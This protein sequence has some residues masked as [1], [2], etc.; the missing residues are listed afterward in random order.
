VPVQ[1]FAGP[2]T[3]TTV[4]AA[5]TLVYLE[6]GLL[7]LAGIFAAMIGVVLG[8]GNAIAFAGTQVSGV[9]AAALGV[10]YAALGAAAFYAAVELGRLTPWSRTAAI[11]LQAVL[12]V[13]FMAR[14]DFSAS[15]GL[16]LALCIAV[17]ALL[18]TPSATAALRGATP[19][20]AGP[21]AHASAAAGPSSPTQ[22]S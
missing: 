11:V 10:F 15:L 4:R 18:L 9:G 19:S 1:S 14:G 17:A 20:A 16:S 8:S 12:I 21:G 5:R 22:R 6:C 7:L 13:I 3:P 2:P